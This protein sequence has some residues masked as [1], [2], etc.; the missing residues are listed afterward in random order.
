MAPHDSYDAAV[1]CAACAST[2]LVP[3]MRVAGSMGEEGLIP[4]TDRFGSAL[5][6]LVRCLAC[7]HMQLD[8]FP[9]DE[10]LT[11]AYAE[12]A[13]DDYVGEEVGQRATA[14]V[15]LDRIERHA[16]RGRLLDVGCWVGF[17]MAE[18]RD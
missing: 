9:S 11:A 4:T 18:A 3:H 5:G 6:D 12:A 1:P 7:G 17:L 2:V 16:A 8:S 15:T 13:S 10:D 14:R